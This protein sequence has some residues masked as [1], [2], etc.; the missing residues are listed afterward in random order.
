MKIITRVWKRHNQKT[1]NTEYVGAY[2]YFSNRGTLKGSALITKSTY[3]E[4]R[5]KNN[6][7]NSKKEK[8]L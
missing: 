3:D 1:G 8:H 6:K 2:D 7:K 4:F 5:K